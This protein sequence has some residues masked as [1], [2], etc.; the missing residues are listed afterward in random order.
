[1]DVLLKQRFLNSSPRA[2]PASAYFCM[3][4][5]VNTPDSDNHL[6]RSALRAWTVSWLTCSPTQG[7]CSLHRVHCSLHRVHCSPTQCPLPLHRVH[8]SLHSV[9]CYLHRVHLLPTQCPLLPTQG[10]LLP[11]QCPL[12]PTQGPLLPTPWAGK[13]AE[14]YLFRNI[15]SWICAAQRLTHG[16][17]W[18]HILC[19]Y[20]QFK[21]TFLHTSMHFE[22]NITLASNW[23]HGGISWCPLRR[24]LTV[25]IEQNIWSDKSNY[26]I[27]RTGGGVRTGLISLF[28]KS[29][30][31]FLHI[32]L[33]FATS[34][35]FALFILHILLLFLFSTLPSTSP[36]ST[37]I[38]GS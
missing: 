33:F 8:C 27:C 5:F 7:P 4:L 14:V 1:M 26:E 36:I 31:S 25:P 10:P 35:C 16:R 21:F 6:V 24:A 37:F 2:P 30:Y 3:S 28:I 34:Y 19:K 13:S 29:Q 18:H 17:V 15:H 38:L 9:H 12:L 20:I 11:T 32:L 23:N 22:W